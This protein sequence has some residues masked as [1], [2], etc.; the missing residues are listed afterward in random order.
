MRRASNA[1]LWADKELRPSRSIR[2]LFAF[3][4]RRSAILL[5]GGDKRGTWT[6]WY[7]R[8]VPQADSL[9]AEHPQSLEKE[10]LL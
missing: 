5:L 2:V 1:E 8:M 3:D 9:Y 4:P 10:G 6:E 7:E